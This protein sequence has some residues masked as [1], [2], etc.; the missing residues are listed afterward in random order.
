MTDLPIKKEDNPSVSPEKATEKQ[1]VPKA[2]KGM[3]NIQVHAGNI[4][5]LT[6]Q[7]LGE[8]NLN[9]ARLARCA[10]ILLKEVVPEKLKEALPEKPKEEKP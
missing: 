3:K 7:M 10:E 2:P 1:S 8:I 5:P 6:V 9:M 4:G